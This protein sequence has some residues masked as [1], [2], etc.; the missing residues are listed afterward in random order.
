MTKSDEE[1][2]RERQA[3][4]RIL[5]SELPLELR[6]E[7][8]PVEPPVEVREALLKRILERTVRTWREWTNGSK[9]RLDD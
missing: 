6:T 4:I 1:S 2:E 3:L 9:K 5:Q 8:Q 7:L